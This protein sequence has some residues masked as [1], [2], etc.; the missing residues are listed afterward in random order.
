M[1]LR[2]ITRERTVHFE[3]EGSA[4]AED[5]RLH[6]KDDQLYYALERVGQ[7]L[8]EN[9]YAL[10]TVSLT[11]I[12]SKI[13]INQTKAKGP[14]QKKAEDFFTPPLNLEVA[15]QDKNRMSTEDIND[16]LFKSI[17]YIEFSELDISIGGKRPN[18]LKGSIGSQE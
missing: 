12:R 4:D 15:I 5:K 14:F 8:N 18:G 11:F 17:D 1:I 2:R 13:T 16:A 3:N 9:V 7:T 10:R 6:I